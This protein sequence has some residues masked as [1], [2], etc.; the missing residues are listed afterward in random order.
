MENWAAVIAGGSTRT[1][2]TIE[3]SKS[4][5]MAAAAA[6]APPA[7]APALRSMAA[8][9]R[10]VA[11]SLICPVALELAPGTRRCALRASMVETVVTATPSEGG[12][13][14]GGRELAGNLP[15]ASIALEAQ[16]L[17]GRPSS[18]A[19]MNAARTVSIT[20][21][22]AHSCL[23]S[24]PLSDQMGEVADAPAADM[25]IVAVGVAELDGAPDPLHPD[26]GQDGV[27]HLRVDAPAGEQDDRFA[28]EQGRQVVPI[29]TRDGAGFRAD[30]ASR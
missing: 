14:R 18:T 21:E 1:V 5:I 6:S 20:T 11:P 12:G 25:E 3:A 10:V 30:R 7:D 2:S 23:A 26:I 17:S 16:S 28:L 4:P 19:A 24:W 27:E 8:M 13:G 9:A 29:D 15:A 22:R